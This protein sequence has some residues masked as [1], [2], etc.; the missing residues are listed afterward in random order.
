MVVHYWLDATDEDT[1]ANML[2]TLELKVNLTGTLINFHAI[3]FK[4]KSTCEYYACF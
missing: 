4:L 2:S 3:G 1:T